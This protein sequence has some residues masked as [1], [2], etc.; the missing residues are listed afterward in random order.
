M[1][2]NNPPMA[3]PNGQVISLRAVSKLSE[4][5]EF[6]RCPVTGESFRKADARKVYVL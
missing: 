6:V 3:L 4:G 5:S 2:E 1:N